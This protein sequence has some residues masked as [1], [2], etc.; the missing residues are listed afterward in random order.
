MMLPLWEEPR[1]LIGLPL[2]ACLPPACLHVTTAIQSFQS[3]GSTPDQVCAHLSSLISTFLNPDRMKPKQSPISSSWIHSKERFSCGSFMRLGPDFQR[4]WL[5]LRTAK[6]F[7]W[8]KA[9]L[10]DVS[11]FLV[12]FSMNGSCLLA[13]SVNARFSVC[14]YCAPRVYRVHVCLGAGSRS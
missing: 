12:C 4:A 2:H 14:I 3:L 6:L 10:I 1:V 11:V 7:P 8:S 13:S 5:S 9:L